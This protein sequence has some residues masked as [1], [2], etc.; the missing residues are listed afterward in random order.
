VINLVHIRFGKIRS[1][2]SGK[3]KPANLPLANKQPLNQMK[4]FL[5]ILALA[6]LPALASG[7]PAS[8]SILQNSAGQKAVFDS[9]NN[10]MWYWD[11]STFASEPYAQQLA[12]IQQLNV[13]S[14]FGLTDWHLASTA[15]M[16]PLWTL[17][18]DTIRLDFNPTLERYED[19]YEWHYWSGRF[20]SG[21]AGSHQ[22]SATGWGNFVFGPWDYAWPDIV[23]LDD[24]SG[25]PD[26]GGAWIVSTVPEPQIAALLSFGSAMILFLHQ[27]RKRICK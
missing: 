26:Y 20:E 5:Q 17:S 14:Y 18:S 2:E 21:S 3:Q 24:S 23:G 15:E 27:R 12:G 19:S 1:L 9:A 25:S 11:L 8:L 13:D 10:E 16:E 4:T 6:M 22:A 7:A